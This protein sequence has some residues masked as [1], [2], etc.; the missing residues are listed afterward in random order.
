MKLVVAILFVTLNAFAIPQLINYQAQLTHPDGTP[1]DTTVAMTFNIWTAPAGGLS[2]WIEAHPAVVVTDGLF[3]VQLGSVNPL[4]DLYAVNR[5]LGVTIGGDTE[6][7]PR[8]QMVSVAHAYRVG[9]VDGASGGTITSKINIGPGNTNAGTNACVLGTSNTAA[10]N[11]SQVSGGRQN[12]ADTTYSTAGGGYGNTASGYGSTAGG[13]QYN[14]ARGTFAVVGGGGST[15]LSDS[16][17]ARGDYSVIGGGRD[18]STSGS[19]ATITGGRSNVATNTGT[20]VGGGESNSADSVY[21]TA[22]GG[23]NNLAIHSGATIGG[24]GYNRARGLY[25]VIAGGGGD[26]PIDS[27]SATAGIATIGGGR[28]NS[29]TGGYGTVG[30]GFNNQATASYAAV[31]AGQGNLASGAS[32]VVAGGGGNESSGGQ[33]AVGGG[34]GNTA[35]G[36]AAVVGGGFWNTA[37]GDTATVAGGILNS[38]G[39]T[40]AAI[41]GGSNNTASGQGATIGGGAWNYARGQYS[42]VGGGGSE[43][44][45]DSNSA[46]GSASVILGGRRN[47]TSGVLAIAAGYRAKANH[48]GSFVWADNLSSDFASTTTNQFNIRASGGTRIFSN[49]GLTAGVTLAAGGNAWVGVSDS[50]KKRNIRSTDTKD[51]LDKLASLPI[52]DWEYKSETAGTEHMGPMAQD[53]WKAYHLGSDSLGIATNDADGVLFAAVQELAKQSDKQQAEIAELRAMVET[54]IAEKQQAEK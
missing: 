23:H 30:G 6:M 43:L 5:W 34:F 31:G 15:L 2:E 39:N 10:G 3:S 51:V 18:N 27:N 24:G 25:S 22:S 53:F 52:K 8:E 47:E 37:S 17:S 45:S 9:T 16:N 36:F 7:M 29:V 42:V 44:Q 50:T 20:T 13:G 32:S 46:R 19:H 41:G 4:P 35:A 40:V 28:R 14:F 11:Y 1:L 12:R 48:S 33:A 54:L 26:S 21:S 38:A 49:S